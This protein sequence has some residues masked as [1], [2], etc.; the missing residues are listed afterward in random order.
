MDVDF[1]TRF[2]N[3]NFDEKLM[4]N[5]NPLVN[6]Q[7]VYLNYKNDYINTSLNNLNEYK[8]YKKIF[9]ELNNT[10]IN[11]N[12]NQSNRYVFVY[13]N[14]KLIEETKQKIKNIIIDQEKLLQNF[15]HYIDLLNTNPQ[16]FGGKK[17]NEKRS[18][19]SKLF[20]KK[21]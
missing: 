10:N 8:K 17:Q 19:L 1:Y 16:I 12:N 3:I 20:D 11:N 13:K 21:N 14:T 15:Q 2:I 9:I 5:N 6:S 4:E 18:F 7:D